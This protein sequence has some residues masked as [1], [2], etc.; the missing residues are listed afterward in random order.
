MDFF[1][2][3]PGAKRTRELSPEINAITEAIIAACIEVHRLLGPGLN[4]SIYEEALCHEF[5]LRGVR[6]E[7]QVELPVFYKDKQVGLTRVDLLV[8]GKVI[9]ELKACQ[10]LAEVHRAQL[11]TYLQI[12]K[13]EI[14][15]LINF[16]HVRLVDGIR[17]VVRTFQ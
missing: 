8:D 2:D 13:L 12:T 15:L 10:Q 17:R 14:G 4:E 1:S 16:N 6:Y 11:L 5:D 3:R 9:V 7:E